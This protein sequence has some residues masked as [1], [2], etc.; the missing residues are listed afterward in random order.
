MNIIYLALAAMPVYPINYVV[1]VCFHINNIHS[2]NTA[3]YTCAA[4][5]LSL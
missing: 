4:V 3:S 5:G 1:R 2:R